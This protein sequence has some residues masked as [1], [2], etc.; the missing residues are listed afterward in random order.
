[1]DEFSSDQ[2]VDQ[3]TQAYLYNDKNRISGKPFGCKIEVYERGRFESEADVKRFSELLSSLP[4]DSSTQEVSGDQL[5]QLAGFLGRTGNNQY[6]NPSMSPGFEP[7]FHISS[8]S[9][10]RLKNKTALQIDGDFRGAD[11][12][13]C[14]YV[15]EPGSEGRVYEFS[16]STKNESVRTKFKPVFDHLVESID[17]N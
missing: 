3:S 6:S 1:M 13:S 4:K 8:A 7:D 15:Y 11:K 5:K 9:L 14:I 16:L 12:F 2:A 17:W 10:V